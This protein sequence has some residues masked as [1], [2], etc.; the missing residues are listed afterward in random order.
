MSPGRRGGATLST[1]ILLSLIAIVHVLRILWRVEVTADG[2]RIPMWVSWV[3]VLV[4]GILSL[5]LWR[6]GRH[7]ESG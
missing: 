2:T 4:T 3:A 1:T 5:A 7:G 6:E